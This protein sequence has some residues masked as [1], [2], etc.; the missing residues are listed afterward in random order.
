MYRAVLENEL[1]PVIAKKEYKKYLPKEIVKQHSIFARRPI[2]EHFNKI[3]SSEIK[4]ANT[5]KLLYFQHFEEI[6]PNYL[7]EEFKAKM[8]QDE[9]VFNAILR[10]N[11]FHKTYPGISYC[12]E[13]GNEWKV[14]CSIDELC[15]ISAREDNVSV[16]MSRRNGIPIHLQFLSRP[17]MY[18]FVSLLDGYFRLL[19]KW[20]FNLCMDMYTPSLVRLQAIKCH[21]PVGGN[22]SYAKLQEKRDCKPGCYILRESEKQYEVYFLD[23]CVKGRSKPKTFKIQKT[24]SGQFAFQ[25]DNQN[26][27]NIL[28]II[29]KYKNAQGELRLEE[30]IPPSEFDQ[31]QLLLCQLDNPHF[32]NAAK[33]DEPSG[34]HFINHKNIQV[35]KGDKK[36]REGGIC[37]VYRCVLTL[38]R[39]IKRVCAMKVVMT[40]H[41]ERYYKEYAQLVNQWAFLQSNAVVKFYGI[42]LCNPFSMVT[43]Y[44]K[45]GPLDK[46]LQTHKGIIAPEDLVE[47]SAALSTAL[48][49]M[50]EEGIVHG[51]IRCHQLMVSAHTERT[52]EVKLTD[53]GLPQYTERD[54]P[55]IPI[56]CYGNLSLAG[57]S[58]FADVWAFGTT[59]WQIFSFGK[60]PCDVDVSFY[61][62]MFYTKNRLPIPEDCPADIYRLLLETWNIDFHSRK[63]PQA[64]LR[65]INQQMY[66]VYNSRR[67]HNYAIPSEP[68]RNLNT[69]SSANASLSASS[70]SLSS[71]ATD[72]TDL[73]ESKHFF[74]GL[75]NG[76]LELSFDN[77]SLNENDPMDFLADNSNELNTIFDLEGCHV[78]VLSRI[79][80]GNY[81]EV[82]QGKMSSPGGAVKPERLVAIKQVRD[83]G[84][85]SNCL[86]D[87]QR[88]INIMKTLEHPN[89]V[90]IIGVVEG[91]QISLVMEFV[92]HGSLDCYLKINRD[93][94]T[95]EQLLKFALDIAKGMNYL[96]QKK[97]VHRDLAARNI[98]VASEEHVK[99]S[100]FGLAQYMN[101]DNHYQWRT[102]RELPI[103][104]YA[105]ESML[106]GLFYP[107]SD[108]WSYGVTLYELFSYGEDPELKNDDNKPYENNI[109]FHEAL[110]AGQRLPCPDTC[111]QQVY[112]KLMVPCW[113][114][115]MKDRPS[116][117]KLIEIITSISL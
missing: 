62:K 33:S 30:C 75:I 67:K 20:T 57:K 69:I 111:P 2:L 115:E 41:E 39:S 77:L 94:I 46:Y 61:S 112:C 44:L 103:K 3:L 96:G 5:V 4:E 22:F 56:E 81:G 6:A 37:A 23:V 47:A 54:I 43:E 15:F 90:Q 106:Q 73:Y 91:P 93:S 7:T 105:P 19:S 32:K 78:E 27:P 49:H 70:V 31:S 107:L 40:E 13:K 16:E 89:I 117:F 87:F 1:D 24:N 76:G 64:I 66:Q 97:I 110:R 68:K 51:N 11:P 95:Q 108:V 102:Q 83:N 60:N 71:G 55:W 88:E 99:I 82:F 10:V 21:G 92:A 59:L 34:P 74:N 29:I 109:K 12:K 53:P 63:R 17:I 8:D 100:D 114:F 48:W 45:S 14:L 25:Y 52:F 101:S 58:K 113:E 98:L 80:S 28:D 79:G 84:R 72:L 86:I 38:P 85:V 42:T 26:Y 9:V 50:E 116:F 36:F 35:F 65:D 18:S 104:W